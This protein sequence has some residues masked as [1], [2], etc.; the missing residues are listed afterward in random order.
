[1]EGERADLLGVRD[2]LDASLLLL[3]GV[4]D[5]ALAVADAESLVAAALYHT[6][7]AIGTGGSAAASTHLSEAHHRVQGALEV[8]QAVESEDSA[9]VEMLPKLAKC[10]GRLAYPTFPILDEP[11]EI[12][13]GFGTK[14]PVR[15]SVD[16]PRILDPERPVL[17]PSVPVTM[18]PMPPPASVELVRPAGYKPVTSAAELD[19]LLAAAEQEAA[20][21]E[22]PRSVPPPEMPP[23][24]PPPGEDEVKERLYGSQLRRSN[25][26]LDRARSF[27][28][29]ISMMRL[30]RKPDDGDS[31][32]EL[33][34]VEQRL[35]A[36]VDAIIACGTWVLPQLV[37]MLS[38]RPIEDPD[39]LWALLFIHGSLAGR[40]MI[41]AVARLSEGSDVRDPQPYEAV[42]DALSHA[43]HPGILGIARRWLERD[44][45]LRRAAG[46]DVLRRSNAATYDEV[47]RASRD[48]DVRVVR[49]AAQAYETV[50]GP[51]SAGVLWPLLHHEDEGVVRASI[52]SALARGIDAGY[53]RAVMLVQKEMGAFAGALRYV[54][55]AGAYSDL[56]LIRQ[57]AASLREPVVIDAIGWFGATELIPYLLGRLNDG[58][59]I[60]AAALQRITGFS[61]PEDGPDPEFHEDDLPFVRA[62]RAPDPPELLSGDPE[63]WGACWERYG[64]RAKN[65]RY[66]WGHLWAPRDSLYEIDEGSTTVADRR[67]AYL[68][69]TAR[70]GARLALDQEAFVARQKR[71]VEAWHT[72]LGPSQLDGYRGQWPQRM[73]G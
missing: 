68:E 49:V 16:V 4:R 41:D 3:R 17:M 36:R 55:I 61:I 62:P 6:Y 11:F 52:E 51:V 37:D 53:E 65:L 2:D 38:E 54:A 27:I 45:P 67:A 13:M 35:L 29:D 21:M 18:R 12:P 71:Q 58:E 33:G 57:C 9:V 24:T 72:M 59:L 66:R 40:D 30:M 28:E 1:V 46:L 60:A 56:D 44:E 23:L 70:S 31:W 34:I 19:A 32:R 14:P 63:R 69:L 20:A 25:V 43:P 42:V 50:A 5:A 22:D 26:E 15:A 39:L 10:L 7:V 47:D 48:P 73:G 64:T 8:L